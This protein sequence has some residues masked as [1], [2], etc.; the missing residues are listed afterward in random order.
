VKSSNES[1]ETKPT[2]APVA[3]SDHTCD[4]CVVCRKGSCCRRDRPSYELP[5]L[6]TW[7]GP[8]Y[9]HL[10]VL[11]R[12][13]RGATCHICGRSFGMLATHV[14]RT[15]EVWAEEYRAYFGLSAKRGL[16]GLDTS[17]RLREVANHVLVPHHGEAVE[18]AHVA[19][20]GKAPVVRGPR[21]RL[22]TRLS[23]RYP[24]PHDARGRRSAEIMRT[25]LE[26]P[27]ERLRPRQHL[28]A[29]GPT[30]VVCTECGTSFV[31]K[32]QGGRIVESSCA[33]KHV[34]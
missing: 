20:L 21:I 29:K 13:E 26:D 25:R 15:H 30:N 10:G 5:E 12:D 16:A 4:L 7:P 22:E 32:L 27:E 19:T 34:G 18:L 28:H 8:I 24:Q 11:Q 9:G 31:S 6:G 2:E 14:W 17:A 33:A 23:E 3:C 1:I